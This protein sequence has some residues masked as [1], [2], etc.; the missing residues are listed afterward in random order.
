MGIGVFLFQSYFIKL[1]VLRFSV[2]YCIEHLIVRFINLLLAPFFPLQTSLATVEKS[3]MK[4]MM[5]DNDVKALESRRRQM[6][7][8]NQ[9]LQQ[10]MQKVAFRFHAAMLSTEKSV[11]LL[12]PNE[13]ITHQMLVKNISI[14]Q[15]ARL[16]ILGFC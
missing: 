14:A 5:L 7:K 8:D 1:K 2:L 10:K 11:C 12:L 4:V 6:E 13:L 9:D 15:V 3:L 16:I